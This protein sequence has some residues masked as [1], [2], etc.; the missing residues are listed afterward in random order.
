MQ[1]PFEIT[2]Y[3]HYADIIQA[4]LERR[5]RAN[6]SFSLRAFA[7]ILNIS[8]STLS[9]IIRKKHGISRQ[10]AVKFIDKLSYVDEEA[11]FFLSLY[12]FI[13]S[14]DLSIRDESYA[15]IQGFRTKRRHRMLVDDE[16]KMISHWYHLAILELVKLNSFKFD[17]DWIAEKL[18]T[19]TLEVMSAISRL[20]QLGMIKVNKNGLEL[21]T[22]ASSS[23][24]ALDSSAVNR[25]FRQCF[26][27]AVDALNYGDP[28]DTCAGVSL[29]AIDEDD[30]EMLRVKMKT[31]RVD[32]TNQLAEKPK[33]TKLYCIATIAYDVVGAVEARR[34]HDQKNRPTV[35]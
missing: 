12:D 13:H 28:Y 18:G 21:V 31:F 3:D 7:R 20:K 4:E 29:V 10:L 22:E 19:S 26:E 11:D 5:Q 16:F 14:P 1:S 27:R 23:L 15:K 34:E 30:L 24:V 8:P 9:E 35:H 32:M 17:Y 25:F 33:K 6:K 2:D